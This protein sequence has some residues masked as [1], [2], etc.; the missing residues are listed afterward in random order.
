VSLTEEDLDAE[1]SLEGL[2]NGGNFTELMEGMEG[3]QSI[4]SRDKKYGQG[5]HL[6]AKL[7]LIN[8]IEEFANKMA[9]LNHMIAV[10][11]QNGEITPPIIKASVDNVKKGLM[12]AQNLAVDVL[13]NL[14]TS[15]EDQMAHS[16]DSTFVANR[17]DL[18]EEGNVKQTK[19]PKRYHGM[20]EELGDTSTLINDPM[21]RLM[22]DSM[23][24]EVTAEGSMIDTD[25]DKHVNN[26]EPDGM[27]L[28][29]LVA[30][31]KQ[32]HT[33]GKHPNPHQKLHSNPKLRQHFRI[34]EALMQGDVSGIH[35]RVDSLHRRMTGKGLLET[36]GGHR[37]LQA[38]L[39]DVFETSCTKLVTCVRDYTLYGKCC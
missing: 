9:E 38:D 4:L 3:M 24:W 28:A 37:R 31:L 36:G 15:F 20:E 7:H 21:L 25:N 5:M 10:L 8:E 34:H 19:Q 16:G 2:D 23:Q 32:E 14:A 17:R 22:E 6:S 12:D 11:E 27:N 18:Q 39:D 13:V 30:A 33:K 26:K 1:Q 29:Q 35:R